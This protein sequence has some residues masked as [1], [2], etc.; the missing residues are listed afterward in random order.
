MLN[1]SIS[2]WVSYGLTGYLIRVPAKFA[3]ILIV[4]WVLEEPAVYG[5]IIARV[6]TLLVPLILN[7]LE[8]KVAPQL[9]SLIAEQIQ[10][11]FNAAAARINLGYLL[12][13]GGTILL[14]LNSG[15]YI[16][17]FLEISDPLFYEVLTWLLIGQAAPVLFGATN[18]FMHVLGRAAFYGII[19]GVTSL[20]FIL[21][22]LSTGAKDGVIVAQTFAAAQLTLAAICALL[23]TQSGV[24]PGLTALFQKKIR[25]F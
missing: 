19:S 16:A 24:W 10:L 4:P 6:A 22:V 21:C 8:R 2:A 17:S 12:V 3:D 18:L 14:I 11:P 13:C 9:V 25:L 1:T 7:L 20:L 23:L 5:Y 15:P